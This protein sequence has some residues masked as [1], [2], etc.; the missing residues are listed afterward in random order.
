MSTS[1]RSVFCAPG[2]GVDCET[3]ARETWV[4]VWGL[5]F[6]VWGLGFGV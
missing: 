1:R 6:G 4:A 5:G 3:F 2:N